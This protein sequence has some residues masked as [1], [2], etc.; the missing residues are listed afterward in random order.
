MRITCLG[1]L[2]AVL[3][4]TTGGCTRQAVYAALQ[5]QQRNRCLELDAPQQGACTAAADTSYFDYERARTAA[6]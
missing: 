4:L 3:G 2:V 6:R 5:T 1:L